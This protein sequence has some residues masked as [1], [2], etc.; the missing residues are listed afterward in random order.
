MAIISPQDGAVSLAIM[1]LSLSLKWSGIEASSGLP[2]GLL[3]NG[4]VHCDTSK[5][6]AMRNKRKR[7]LKR[8]LVPLQ[9]SHVGRVLQERK[10]CSL[11]E[12]AVRNAVRGDAT[13]CTRRFQ[14]L[15]L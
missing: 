6:G 2:H 11:E 4:A 8:W 9:L 10:L 14:P 13:R 15:T 3:R 1:R 12:K 7:R 5:S